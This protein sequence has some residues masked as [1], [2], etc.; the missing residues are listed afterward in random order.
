MFLASLGSSGCDENVV[1]LGPGG[2]TL[3]ISSGPCSGARLTVPSGAVNASTVIS[4]TETNDVRGI[5]RDIDLLCAVAIGPGGLSFKERATLTV[6]FPVVPHLVYIRRFNGGPWEE[7]RGDT[8]LEFLDAA[9]AAEPVDAGMTDGGGFPGMRFDGGF[10]ARIRIERGVDL[11][12]V[13]LVAP[14]PD[15]SIDVVI[16]DGPFRAER[17][18]RPDV[19]PTLPDIPVIVDTSVPPVDTSVAPEDVQSPID[20][21]QPADV[22]API[23]VAPPPADTA[24]PPIDTAPAPVDVA[25]PPVDTAPPPVDTAPPPVDTA[26]APPDVAAVGD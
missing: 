11:A 2:G 15:S 25:P 7:L 1:R 14:R 9:A 10:E 6:P 18:I 26:P 22:T 24:P 13:L 12:F 4:F 23:D 20:T 3:E 17:P 21:A 8:V 16:V 5:P 19:P